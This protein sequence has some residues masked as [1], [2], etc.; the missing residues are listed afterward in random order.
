VDSNKICYMTQ[1]FREKV[2]NILRASS[3]NC[4]PQGYVVAIKKLLTGPNAAEGAPLDWDEFGRF[5]QAVM[6]RAPTINVL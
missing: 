6:R 4:S 1:A 5:A 2:Q 3:R